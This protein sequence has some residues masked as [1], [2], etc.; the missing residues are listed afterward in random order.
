MIQQVTWRPSHTDPLFILAMDHR[1]SFGKTLFHVE[2]DQPT[3]AQIAQ[4]RDAKVLIYSA[5]A[6]VRTELPVG[7]AAVLVDERYGQA[8]IEQ[9]RRDK[10]ILAV[11]VEASGH[12]WFTLEWAEHWLDHVTAVQPDYAK[13]LVRDNPEFD[14]ADR[15]RQLNLLAEVSAGLDG[16]GV[17]LI[18]ELL[19]PAT[20][21]Q[22]R[23][24]GNDGDRYDRD[25]RPELTIRVIADNQAAG[26]HPALWKLEGFDTRDAARHVAAQARS[27]DRPA[28]IILL[29]RDAPVERL[30]HWIDVAAGVDDVVGFAIGRSI[31]EAVVRQHVS[32]TIDRDQAKACIAENYLHFVHRWTTDTRA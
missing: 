15:D 21:E 7:R 3:P 8:V 28:D 26:I 2:G 19:V 12:D 14:P 1:E 10:T 11:P 17:P 9:A 4:M 32:A 18:Y 24:V 5:L 31:W 27:G 25:I 6:S 30:D 29:G 23:S 20:D 13:V 22:K 16:T